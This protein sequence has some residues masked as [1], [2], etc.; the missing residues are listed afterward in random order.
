MPS[1]WC[2]EPE[3]TFKKSCLNVSRL[4]I[5][6]TVNFIKLVEGCQDNGSGYDPSGH[7][8]RICR[9]ARSWKISGGSSVNSLSDRYLI[10]NI[11]FEN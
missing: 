1:V 3:F 8:Y 11:K 10:K 2:T 7:T 4:G 5:D 9:L 6:S